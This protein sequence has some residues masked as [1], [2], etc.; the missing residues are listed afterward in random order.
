MRYRPL[1]LALI[2]VLAPI[3]THA[4]SR[5]AESLQDSPFS[6][7]NTGNPRNGSVRH[8]TNCR[9]QTGPCALAGVGETAGAD[10]I[11]LGGSWFCD[12]HA[13]GAGTGN[14]L[15]PGASVDNELPLFSSTSGSTLKRS[16]SLSGV[17]RVT[18]GVVSALATTGSGSV[19][20]NTDPS[21]TGLNATT[22]FSIGTIPPARVISGTII[23]DRCL[24]V[25]NIG[26]VA[27]AANDCGIGGG[28]S[29]G[30]STGNLSYNEAGT[31]G[32]VVNSVYDLTTGRLTFTQ[33]ANGNDT[34]NLQRFTDSL[35]TGT[36]LRARNAAN[37]ADLFSLS[38][39]GAVNL[40]STI[41]FTLTAAPATPASGFSAIW[42]ATTDKN[43][44]VKDDAGNVS[45]T[46]R[47]ITCSG[48]DKISA[49]SAA[50]VP[51]C[52]ADQTS[53]GGTGITSLNA[54]TAADQTL[55]DVDDT[56]VTLTIGSVTSTH[57]FTLGWTGALAKSR[58][59]AATVYNDAANTWSTGAQ[60]FGAA[61]SLKVPTSA[62]TAPTANGLVAYDSTSNTLEYGENG[63]N[64]I[65]V[66]TVG[67]QTLSTKTLDNSTTYAAKDTL[68]TLQD[69]ADATK[70]VNFELGGL[71]TATNRV[72]TIVDAASMTVRPTTATTNQWV[73]HID[74]SGIQ[75]KAQPAFSNLSGSLAVTQG[76]TG[77]TAVSQG[78]LL[79]GD[80]ANSWARLAKST[81]ATRYLC[82]TGASNNP[83]WCQVD[84]TNGV[85]GVLPP[86]N[87]SP[88]TTKGDLLVHNGT[89]T[90][91]QAVGTDGFALLSDSTQTNGVRWAAITATAG[92]STTQLQRNLAGALAGIS[93]AA[94][95]GTVVTFT[96]GALVLN[97]G[98]YGAS[99]E[100]L[101]GSP[102][103]KSFYLNTNTSSR[104]LFIYNNAAYRALFQAGIDSV[105]LASAN[106]TGILPGANGGTNN[107]FMD[108]TGP[109][110]SLKTFTLPNA[111]ATILTT[112]AAVT[113][114]QGGTGLTS[115][116]SG[117]IPYFSSST[118]IASSAA[119]TANLPVIG[120][121]AGAAPTVGTRSGNTTAFVTTTGTLTSGRCAE[122]DA[123]GNLIQAAA[124][125]G[126]G[127]GG[128]DTA[129]SNLAAVA[130]NT[131]L[132]SDTDLTDDLGSG[133]IRWKDIWASALSLTGRTLSTEADQTVGVL[134]G[135]VTLTKNDTNVRTFYGSL[136]KPVF[137]TGG[138]NT[139]TTFNVLAVDTTNT[140]VTG[141]TTNL[142]NLAYGGSTKATITSGGD[143]TVTGTVTDSG[144]AMAHTIA[145]GTATLGTSAIASGA[146]ATVV[147][148]AATGVA[149]TDV[150]GWGFNG[151]PIAVTGYVPSA[152]GMLTIIAYPTANNVNFVVANNTASS[153]TPG[154]ITLNW[155]VVR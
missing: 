105:N 99:D 14:V 62:G 127:G 55:A 133:G 98:D 31:F 49:I 154:A 45:G 107:G 5:T 67:A 134:N 97:G 109:A 22:T 144:G 24:R 125:C 46:V 75:Q 32:G 74:S 117:G 64:R 73:T 94:S 10:A 86:A 25:N 155:R 95:D 114:A 7:L 37:D 101:P 128:A 60:D 80:A 44:Q 120:G 91:R 42:A 93:G 90:T 111:S 102:V 51:T 140:A 29:P 79:Y 61:T 132:I 3:V 18:A 41:T 143:L 148:V 26:E 122:W 106:I 115:G 77:Q 145:S 104:R 66:N 17:V 150:V 2:L 59:H 130:V 110:T 119:L 54:L 135:A 129:L 78:D 152:N 47:A 6:S 56:N 34:L 137:N 21:I 112:N 123:S 131:S 100:S 118:T 33:K 65:V 76:G 108:F 139:N 121:G 83:A 43:L 85:T 23:N 92:G 151:S 11:K 40:N 15:G 28:G 88:L 30:G 153:I 69:N 63:T 48:S 8:C 13:T 35:P 1:W 70:T 20:L 124:A 50:G 142:L 36:L 141:L 84:L 27:V 113:V 146:S 58:Q 57:T 147:T 136:L 87:W 39:T 126:T 4:Q 81:A 53:P 16:N 12:A 89:T 38:A 149:T 116:T 138:S 82:N 71:T 68:F 9:R 96:D 19:V 52:S 72:V 103:E